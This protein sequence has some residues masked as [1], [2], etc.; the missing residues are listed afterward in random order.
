MVNPLKFNRNEYA[1]KDQFEAAQLHRKL[2]IELVYIGWTTFNNALMKFDSINNK[3]DDSFFKKLLA[4]Q[5]QIHL[6]FILQK[7]YNIIIIYLVYCLIILFS[8][9]SSNCG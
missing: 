6:E 7:N 2:D 8:I 1:K 3:I 4:K 5:Y 9:K